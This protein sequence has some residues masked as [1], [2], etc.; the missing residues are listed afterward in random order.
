MTTSRVPLRTQ[1]LALLLATAAL[2]VLVT[3]LASTA[4][5]RGYLLDQV[6]EQLTQTL[7]TAIGPGGRRG[8]DGGPVGGRR[9]GRLPAPQSYVTAVYLADGTLSD[10]EGL[11]AQ[12]P[13]G[14]DLPRLDITSARRLSPQPFTVPAVNRSKQWRVAVTPLGTAGSLV[15][16][17]P[18]DVDE[19]VRR[20][21]VI[22]GL[23]GLV[24]LGAAG[25]L[26]WYGVRRSLR[27][28]VEVEATAEAIAAGDLTRRV[29]AAHPRTEVGSLSA[30]FNSMVDRFETA[31]RAQRESETAARASEDR[32][33]RFVAD[34]SHE[35]RTPLTSIRGFAELFRQGAVPDD[36]SRARVLRRIEDEAARMGLLVEDLLLLARLDQ[37]RPLQVQPVDLLA[38]SADVVHD[39][40]AVHRGHLVRLQATQ[41]DRPPVVAGDDARLRQVL[42]NLVRNAVVHTPPGTQVDVEVRTEVGAAVLTV[43]DDGPGMEAD[44]ADR[45]FERFY[46]ADASRTRTQAATGSGL[47]LSIVAALVAAH[48]GTVELDTGPGRGTA[49]TVRLPLV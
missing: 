17:V 26:A 32:M 23:A 5:L 41:G 47:G 27:P 28:L 39:A 25:A 35:L 48:G 43:R 33:R 45:V 19:T 15:V 7:K 22:E 38:L 8:P 6:D 18:L 2:V 42:G 34:A 44:V 9:G 46:R 12:D 29:P 16:A 14:P 1:L 40:A 3:G 10:D 30:S 21:L 31:Y 11:G 24:A 13:S 36:A 37:Q 4:V 49:F 20:L